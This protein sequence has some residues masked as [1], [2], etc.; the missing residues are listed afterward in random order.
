MRACMCVYM[1]VYGWVRACVRACMCVRACACVCVCMGGAVTAKS[2]VCVIL[3]VLNRN[4][5][6][7]ESAFL[8]I[9]RLQV[10]LNFF[11]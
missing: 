4:T 10:P 6:L 5:G 7:Q 2:V 1:C 9:I 8:I 11:L 3:N